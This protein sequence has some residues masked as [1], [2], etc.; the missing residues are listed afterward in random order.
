MIGPGLLTTSIIGNLLGKQTGT[1]EPS[2]EQYKNTYNMRPELPPIVHKPIQRRVRSSAHD[3]PLGPNETYLEEVNPSWE[4]EQ[5]RARGGFI[6]S[7]EQSSPSYGR[8]DMRGGGFLLGPTGGHD[9]KI[10]AELSDGEYVMPADVV[11]KMGDGNNLAGARKFDA[12]VQNIRNHME[13]NKFPP[14]ARSIQAY[15]RS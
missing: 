12:F 8:Q 1:T 3:T 10:D 2:L 15:M 9:D 14:K 5:R 11:S 13:T 7:E 4:F 6:D